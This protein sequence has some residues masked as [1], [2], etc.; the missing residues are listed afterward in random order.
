MGKTT[1]YIT[2]KLNDIAN[3]ATQSTP[4][5]KG[6]DNEKKVHKGGYYIP[7]FIPFINPKT[8]EVVKAIE[9]IDYEIVVSPPHEYMY[10]FT[11]SRTND[12][13]WFSSSSCG[14]DQPSPFGIMSDVEGEWDPSGNGSGNPC[15][16][17]HAYGQT[18][19]YGP[20]VWSVT[21]CGSAFQN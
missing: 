10:P 13:V 5:R 16:N 14:A 8:G 20:P 3:N 17:C 7:K 18:F 15:C 2:S 6:D 12:T 21:P 9:G 4:I 1:Y 11:N 19:Y